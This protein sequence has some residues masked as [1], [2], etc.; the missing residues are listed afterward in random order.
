MDDKIKQ[1]LLRHMHSVHL[2]GAIAASLSQE[3]RP[4][5]PSV[6]H[7]RLLWSSF[8]EEH[9]QSWVFERH[10]RMPLT[11]FHKLLS[12]VKPDL[13]VDTLMADLR[14]GPILPEISLY[15]TLRYLA[16][17]SYADIFIFCGISKAS[18]YQVIYKTMDSICRAPELSIKFC[19]TVE[20]CLEAAEGFQ[21]CTIGGCINN[22]VSVIDGYHL[23]IETPSKSEVGNVRSCFSGHYQTH[24]VNVQAA[25]EVRMPYCCCNFDRC[26]SPLFSL[27][28]LSSTPMLLLS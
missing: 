14:G 1:A 11:S 7:Q 6:F 8:L 27:I 24:G 4:R 5:N 9:G 19:E 25:C 12:Y 21:Q 18:F 22:C 26:G 15:C 3:E 23:E 16:G 10:M 17:G 28:F 20:E 2:L 13:A